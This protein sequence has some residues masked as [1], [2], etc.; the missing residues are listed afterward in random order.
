[1]LKPIIHNK[2]M[3]DYALL[4]RRGYNLKKLEILVKKIIAEEKLE[5]KYKEHALIGNY[6]GCKEC[7][8]E[9]DW[10]LIYEV[11]ENIVYFIRTGTHSDL[12]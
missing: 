2:F 10:L 11:S 9:P 1:M 7:H 6:K 8:I 12:F 5:K 3:K 4:K